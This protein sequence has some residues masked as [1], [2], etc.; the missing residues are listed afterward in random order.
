M[1]KYVGFLGV[2]VCTAIFSIVFYWV[3]IDTVPPY[4][5]RA[6]SGMLYDNGSPVGDSPIIPGQKYRVAI[7]RCMGTKVQE[8]ETRHWIRDKKDNNYIAVDYRRIPISMEALRC[9]TVLVKRKIP[10]DLSPGEYEYVVVLNFQN[11]PITK[12]V[13]KLPPIKFKVLQK[14]TSG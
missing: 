12:S 8:I 4:E 2:I 1:L 9:R 13:F 5:L 7:D 6:Q 10:V 3:F 11:N 14:G